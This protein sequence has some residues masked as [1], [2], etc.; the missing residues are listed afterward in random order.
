MVALGMTDGSVEILDGLDGHRVRSVPDC[1]EGSVRCIC[2]SED[3]RLVC[4]GGEDG[5]VRS[6]KVPRRF[7]AKRTVKPLTEVL[8]THHDRCANM[9]FY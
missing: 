6:I 1:A 9:V 4:F 5:F 7:F 2:V 8:G 3:I